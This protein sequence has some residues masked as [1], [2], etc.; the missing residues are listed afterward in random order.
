MP[1][2]C[3]S[4]SYPI[5]V[6]LVLISFPFASWAQSN[7]VPASAGLVAWWSAE[8]NANDQTQVN[9]GFVQGGVTF[10]PGEVGQS[11]AM[12]GGVDGVKIAASP[13]LNVGAG[14]GLTVEAWI[15]P[16]DLAGRSPL[17]EWNREGTTSTEWGVQ[18][19][20][21]KAGDFVPE[22][23]SLFANLID[24]NGTAHYLFSQG[25]VIVSNAW[26]HIALTYDKSSGIGRLYRNGEK[27]LESNVGVFTPETS[28]SLFLG[29]RPSGASAMSYTGLLDEVAIYDHAL[30]QA[31]L[32]SIYA[33]GSAGKCPVDT[34]GNRPPSISLIPN[35]T[36]T[37]GA[38]TGPLSFTVTDT[39]TPAED[40]VVTGSS[41][42]PVLVPDAN[43][44]LSGSGSNRAVDVTAVTNQT[45]TAIITLTVSDGQAIGA[46]RFT[47]R[48]QVPQAVPSIESIPDHIVLIDQPTEAIQLQLTDSDTPLDALRLTGASSN[49]SLVPNENIFFGM[50]VGK[51][52]TTVTPVFGQTGSAIVTVK[53][54][55]GANEAATQFRLT[56]NPPPAGTAR[57]INPSGMTIPSG[58]VADL[59]P[60]QIHVS[61]MNGSVTKLVLSIDK[62]SHA[63][64]QDVNMLLVSPQGQGVV[65]FSHVSGTRP[66]SNVRVNL[67]DSSAYFLPSN[68]S[69]WSEPLKPA[70]YPPTPTFPDPAP[71]GPYG[72]VALSTFNG[73][74]ANGTWSLYVF[75]DSAPNGGSI[76]GGWS[77]SV[78]AS[79]VG[80]PPAISDIPDQSTPANT[81]TPAI[82]FGVSDVDT[83]VED[84]TVTAESS[85]TALVPAGNI[86]VGGS[87]ANRTLTI[88]PATNQF[89]TTIITVRVSDGVQTASDSFTLTVNPPVQKRTL[90]ITVD[91]ASRAYGAA[92]PA[93]TGKLS[94][95]EDGDQITAT[96]ASAATASS[97]AGE[98]PILPILND[99]DGKLSKYIV[100]TNIGTLRVMSVPLAI[101]IENLTRT[102][103]AENPAF[104]GSI[105]GLKN[106]DRI[107]ATYVC[108]ATRA[109]GAGI[110]AITAALNDPDAKLGNYS[111]IIQNATLMVRPAALTVQADNKTRAYGA[112]NPALTGS[113]TGI[114]NSDNIT[115]RYTTTAT[116]G[117]D[118]GNYPITPVIDD[119]DHRLGNYQ[120]TVRNG[121][122]TVSLLP[123]L[124]DP[125]PPSPLEVTVD[126]MSRTYGSAN[127]SLTGTITGL[128][129]GDNITAAFVTTAGNSSDTGVY[130]IKPVL[131]DPDDK[132]RNYRLTTHHGVLTVTAA[133]LEVRADNKSRG[134]GGANPPLTGTIQGLRNG[135][136]ISAT[137][138]ATATSASPVGSYPITPLLND[139]AGKLGNYS[140][141]SQHG[142]LTV[143]IVDA[144]QIVSLVPLSDHCRISG[145]GD[146]DF[147]YNIQGSVDLVHWVD[148]G[149]VQAD[150][151]GTFEFDAAPAA[152]PPLHFFR[153]HLP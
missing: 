91:N 27:V 122:L 143:K 50:A 84:L 21:S 120:L 128:G 77:L 67:T 11:F 96:Y 125:A 114:Q 13:S 139:P 153:V 145:T 60:S 31:E 33:A 105:D 132:L 86:V 47:V 62:F 101:H 142:L 127:P 111:V 75:D 10:E 93:F 65:I 24:N 121:T 108:S 44:Y 141:T 14:T 25:N 53:V 2:W 72:P 34:G 109:S 23:G 87:G 42:N 18:L 140:V 151:T 46:T 37:Q 92:N 149:S 113:I 56:V 150:S 134:Y 32:Q 110:Y 51:W 102:Y 90:T 59:Y 124:L 49:P 107:T 129:N 70:A 12:H 39:E 3:S 99:P 9:P 147:I 95:L 35:Q 130:M 116:S 64:I 126:D 19:W 71:P 41:S 17:I 78:S 8:G 4:Y 48:V 144:I 66:E 135:D 89:G 76:V 112:G 119:P 69:L 15:N 26:Q 88:T 45:G 138:T 136:P 5:R 63:S 74:L 133:G 30:T 146:A 83:P 152:D 85:N 38:S 22:P 61:G 81:P 80:S 106:G 55:D 1:R 82:S 73:G 52:Y 104:T 115:A 97:P 103:G 54:S 28:Y 7:C 40:L 79:G 117:S 43:I 100:L 36:I 29:R 98:Y 20:I 123:G 6:F 148:L 137:Y 118:T 16:R 94:G 131:S 68:F 57:F 58:G